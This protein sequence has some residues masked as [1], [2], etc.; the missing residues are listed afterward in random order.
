MPRALFAARLGL[1][2]GMGAEAAGPPRVLGD[3]ASGFSGA[4]FWYPK[5]G[6]IHIRES[7]WHR[8]AQEVFMPVF[9]FSEL[10]A[11]AVPALHPE[12]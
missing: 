2:K 11:A 1:K 12:Q 7:T 10:L 8:R 4:C 6:A 5:L 3:A 9:W